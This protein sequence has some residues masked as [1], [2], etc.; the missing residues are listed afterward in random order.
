M[1][2]WEELMTEVQQPGIGVNELR[3]KYMNALSE[4]T[5]RNVIAYYSGWLLPGRE[6]NVEVND[7]DMT[8]FM[9]ATRDLDCS[10][11]LDLILHTPGG[12]PNAAEGIVNYLHSMFGSDIRVIVPHMAMSAGTMISCSAS[13]ILMGRH[14]CLGPVDPQFGGVPAYNI[15]KEF[16]TAQKEMQDNPESARYWS[17]LLSKYPMAFHY[18]AQDAIELSDELVGKWLRQY[19]FAGETGNEV[20]NR[21]RR[22]KNK[23]NSNNKSH[24]R[25]YNFDFCRELGMKVEALEDDPELHELVKTIHHAFEITLH[26][27]PVTK[28]IQNHQGDAFISQQNMEG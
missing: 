3:T 1:P 20:T 19:M 27:Y 21:I 23:L 28:L 9:I 18:I 7:R 8:G 2:S 11:G 25:H 13:T 22:I 16:Q 4:K 14:S 5:G 15:V 12:F 10:R 6:D 17:V 24:G 26:A